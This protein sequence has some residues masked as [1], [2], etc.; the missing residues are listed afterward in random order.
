MGGPTTIFQKTGLC[1][2]HQAGHWNKNYKLYAAEIRQTRDKLLFGSLGAAS[3]VRRIDPR[4]G[5]VIAVIDAETGLPM[6][7]GIKRIV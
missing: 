4:T 3:P 2:K 5:N 6:R 7:P 1:R